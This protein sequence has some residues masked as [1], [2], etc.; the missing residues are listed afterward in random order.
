MPLTAF[1]MAVNSSLTISSSSFAASIWNNSNT[2]SNYK[3]GKRS[4][5]VTPT[6][7][8]ML[9]S[10]QRPTSKT[11]ACHFYQGTAI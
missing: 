5:K 4:G 6:S 7:W 2:L 8:P 1:P 9:A 11:S 3:N 10:R